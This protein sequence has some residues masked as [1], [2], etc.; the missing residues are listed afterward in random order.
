[1]LRIFCGISNE[2]TNTLSI[3]ITAYSILH[4]LIYI[5]MMLI[6]IRYFALI[7]DILELILRLLLTQI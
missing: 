4:T 7:L 3:L 6:D 2:I 1:M 5:D